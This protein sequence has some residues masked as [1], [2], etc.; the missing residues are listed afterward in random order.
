M[1][2]VGEVLICYQAQFGSQ[3]RR[4]GIIDFRMDLDRT[5]KELEY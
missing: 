2:D 5:V 3:V 4:H 1:Y